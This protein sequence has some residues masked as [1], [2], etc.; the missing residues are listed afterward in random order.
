MV[1]SSARCSVVEGRH[2]LLV[3][4]DRGAVG[5][6]LGQGPGHGQAGFQHGRVAG[7]AVEQFLPGHQGLAWLFQR[8]SGPA[9][10]QQRLLGVGPFQPHPFQRRAGLLGAAG[11]Q[12]IEA[13]RQVGLVAQRAA[14][15]GRCGLHLHRAQAVQPA[16]AGLGVVALQQR[17]AEVETRVRRALGLV[18]QALQ[19]PRGAGGVAQGQAQ[20]GG[21]Q[22]ALFFQVFGQR[23]LHLRQRGIGRRR[24]A[25]LPAD[26]GQEEPGPVAQRGGGATLGQAGE[27]GLGLA[28]QAVGQQQAAARGLGFVAMRAQALQLLRGHQRGHGRE[29]LALVDV[30]QRVAP[31]RGRHLAGRGRGAAKRDDGKPMFHCQTLT[32]NSGCSL[33]CTSRMRSSMYLASVAFS[34]FSVAPRL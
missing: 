30:E 18:G 4:V 23:G 14:F 13:Q 8:R 16:P 32:S 12:C 6:Q 17:H 7:V 33:A 31:V 15:F 2:G 19:Q 34:N 11:L 10:A 1:C 27:D 3:T 20:P 25:T 28:V 26:L 24:Q 9:E 5:L 21:E 22:L 29:V